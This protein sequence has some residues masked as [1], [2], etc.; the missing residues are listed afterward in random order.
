M[1]YFIQSFV[2]LKLSSDKLHWGNIDLVFFTHM[3]K[4][5][6]IM[7]LSYVMHIILQYTKKEK[8]SGGK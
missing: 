2:I 4:L 5:V 8:K 6:A 1:H 3:A 7:L